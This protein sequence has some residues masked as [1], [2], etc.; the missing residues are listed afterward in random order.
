MYSRGVIAGPSAD[1][2]AKM[3]HS[4]EQLKLYENVFPSWK[5][6]LRDEVGFPIDASY[7]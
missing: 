3:L 7:H 1:V 5:T 4:Q 2:A 6:F